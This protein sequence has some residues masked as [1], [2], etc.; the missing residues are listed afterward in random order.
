MAVEGDRQKSSEEAESKPLAS[1][2]YQYNEPYLADHLILDEQVLMGVT[3]CS[4]AL[5]GIKKIQN[6]GG[7]RIKGIKKLLFVEPVSLNH[8]EEVTIGATRP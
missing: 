4:L 1:A 7:K 8:D 5:D 6:N 2:L 3:Y